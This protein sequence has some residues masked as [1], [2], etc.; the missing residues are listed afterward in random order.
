[1]EWFLYAS[2]LYLRFVY[3]THVEKFNF[4][5]DVNEINL[6]TEKV[7]LLIYKWKWF[8]EG[9]LFQKSSSRL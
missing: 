9:S 5:A 4:S 7:K 8:W 2:F 3:I 1:M 6:C